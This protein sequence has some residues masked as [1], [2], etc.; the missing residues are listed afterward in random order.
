MKKPL[1]G[2][3]ATYI[4]RHRR[5]FD[6]RY[7]DA[8]LAAGGLPLIL[9]PLSDAADAAA[10]L[11]LID[12]L[13]LTGGHD[14]DPELYNEGKLPACGEPDRR[15]DDAELE[16]ILQ[17][18]ELDMPTLGICRGIQ[19]LNAAYGG[20]LYQDIPSQYDSWLDHARKEDEIHAHTVDILGCTPLDSIYGTDS[21]SVN[22]L[23]HQAVKDVAHGL[24]VCAVSDDGLTEALWDP[25]AKFILAVQ[26]HPELMT[27]TDGSAELLFKAFISTCK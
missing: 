6:T 16:L 5:S 1:I 13:L 14:I 21:L 23:H 7:S 4:G 3:T 20:T 25:R 2:I 19:I 26:W 15:R 24:E 27:G 22:S 8:I 18:R 11:S 9:P 10:Q 17:A 12:G